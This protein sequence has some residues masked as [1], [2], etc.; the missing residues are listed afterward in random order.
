[1][2]SRLARMVLAAA[3]ILAPSYLSAQTQGNLQLNNSLNNNTLY[4]GDMT[5][6][7]QNQYQ[8]TH[9]YDHQMNFENTFQG[10]E[11]TTVM[12]PISNIHLQQSNTGISTGAMAGAVGNGKGNINLSEASV[13]GMVGINLNMGG[14]A[15]NQLNLNVVTAFGTK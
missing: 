5:N 9:Q 10:A 12:M 8:Y 7:W 6:A 1:M 15:T 14:A 4:N 2:R 13:N 11:N 3:L